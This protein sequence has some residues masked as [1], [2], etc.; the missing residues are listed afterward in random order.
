MKRTRPCLL[1]LLSLALIP[2]GCG[3]GVIVMPLEERIFIDLSDLDVFTFYDGH[4][5]LC[6]DP[7]TLVRGERAALSVIGRPYTEYNLSV[8][9][10]SGPSRASGLGTAESDS[11]GRIS[12]E[13]NVSAQTRAG[14]VTAIVTGGGDRLVLTVIVE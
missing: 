10:F 8:I 13:W 2:A 5:A 6:G 14:P 4:I 11:D 12:W 1:L 9:L 7:P 3:R